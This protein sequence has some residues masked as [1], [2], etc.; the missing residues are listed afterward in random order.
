MDSVTWFLSLL[1]RKQALLGITTTQVSEEKKIS[2]TSKNIGYWPAFFTY[3][4]PWFFTY[5][6]EE[7]LH[8]RIPCYQSLSI[9]HTYRCIYT[10][11]SGSSTKYWVVY[12]NSYSTSSIQLFG[13]W[14][15]LIL[16]KQIRDLKAKKPKGDTHVKNFRQWKHSMKNTSGDCPSENMWLFNCLMEQCIHFLIYQY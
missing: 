5:G 11:K 12:I 14:I 2:R 10:E 7:K 6:W 13:K 9:Y 1:Y 15:L 4:Q 3:E 16:Y 8:F